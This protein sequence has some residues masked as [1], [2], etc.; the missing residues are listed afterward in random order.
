M[1]QI[2]KFWLA[3]W[4]GVPVLALG[5]LIGGIVGYGP[6]YILSAVGLGILLGAFRWR[7][8]R[9]LDWREASRAVAEQHQPLDWG[10]GS[11]HPSCTLGEA[12][13]ITVHPWA[14]W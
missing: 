11:Q 8:L 10:T 9:S 2:D 4:L 12:Q 5:I 6:G 14:R 13:E 1:T 3:V 7:Y